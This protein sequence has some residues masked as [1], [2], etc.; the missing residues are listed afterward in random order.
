MY[1]P[2]AERRVADFDDDVAGV[3]DGGLRP[4]LDGDVF[5]ALEH[6]GLHCGGETVRVSCRDFRDGSNRL[7]QTRWD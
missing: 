1:A 5:D 2:S 7:R 6:N 4:V 3:S